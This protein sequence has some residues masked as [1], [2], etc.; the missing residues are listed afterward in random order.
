MRRILFLLSLLVAIGAEAQDTIWVKFDNRFQPNKSID[1]SE[2]DSIVFKQTAVRVYIPSLQTGSKYIS[3][4]SLVGTDTVAQFQFDWPGRILYRPSSMTSMN[5]NSESSQ[6]CFKR[7][8]ESEHFVVFWEKGF[9]DNP[10]KASTYKF[11]P[12]SL[13]L[14]GEK[15]WKKN[16]EMGFIKPGDSTTDTY[17]II[18]LV[19]YTGDWIASG[20]G[21]DSK[22]GSF[23]VSPWAITARGG[24][25]VAHEIGHTFQYLVSCDLGM[26][27]GFNY[28]YGDNASGGNGWWESCANWQGYKVYPSR[29]FSDGE[30]YEQHLENHHLNLLHEN[31]RYACC[32]IQDY[33][34][35]LYGN[36][37][38]GR[39]WRESKKPEDPVEAYKR[40]NNLTQEQF[41]DEQYMGY[42]RMATWD[43]DGVRDYAASANR[44]G[45]H[46]RSVSKLSDG[47]T[48]QVDSAW[49][50]QNYGY[51]IMNMKYAKAGTTVK[52][53]FKG[54]AG[55][56][57]YRAIKTDKAGW[58]YGFV[59]YASDGTR[60]YSEMGRDAEGTIEFTLPEKHS[61]LFF[62]VMGAPTEHWHH[63]WDDNVTNDEQW[64]YQVT[65]ENTY[66]I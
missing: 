15:C 8:M 14:T 32:Y 1:I 60:V 34:C 35:M 58:R 25:T 62:V 27:H 17:K 7:S 10:S 16:V 41:N 38:I 46:K 53:T 21:Y 33:W 13:L 61:R 28:G 66:P 30:Y 51:N 24:H 5:F 19:Y 40:I 44:I 63:P 65:F 56:D 20:S 42:A 43:I 47:T 22:V 26:E 55:A 64:P 45:G 3:Y 31:W 49:C 37:F 36:D 11:T 57:G 59:S 2:A 4:S 9:G 18:M 48:W 39:L 54:I 6:W 52:A 29:Q 12:K 50:P 23:N